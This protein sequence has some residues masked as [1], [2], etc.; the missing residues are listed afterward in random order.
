MISPSVTDNP[1]CRHVRRVQPRSVAVVEVGPASS[2]RNI[3]AWSNC[4]PPSADQRSVSERSRLSAAR[5][6]NERSVASLVHPD[7][8]GA[9][10]VALWETALP[11]APSTVCSSDEVAQ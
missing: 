3:A 4:A 7:Q 2:A 6:Q 11:A 10:A 9:N 5:Q 8:I 1:D